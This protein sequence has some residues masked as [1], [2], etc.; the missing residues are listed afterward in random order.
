MGWKK[1][2]KGAK[3]A[4]KSVSDGGKKL[5][6]DS[7]KTVDDAAKDVAD[8]AGQVS[9]Q[10]QKAA[11][12][13]IDETAEQMNAAIGT[14]LD[15]LKSS[16]NGF[17]QEAAKLAADAQKELNRIG[18]LAKALVDQIFLAALEALVDQ[19][20]DD[21]ED[22]IDETVEILEELSKTPDAAVKLADQLARLT[23]RADLTDEV[24]LAFVNL[25]RVVPGFI[26]HAVLSDLTGFK[27]VSYGVFGSRAKPGQSLGADGGLAAASGALS[28]AYAFQIPEKDVPMAVYAGYARSKTTSG[29]TDLGGGLEAASW[30]DAPNNLAGKFL[31]A[32]V[33][34]KSLGNASIQFFF[35]TD[36]TKFLGIN[37]AFGTGEATESVL[38]VF[39]GETVTYLF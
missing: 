35:S 6:E 4:A 11:K 28:K 16:A 8:G 12:T 38:E 39:T 27:S 18:D 37:I 33:T 20:F 24:K 9:K 10:V 30:R 3:K 22:F 1:F 5:V 34:V 15:W 25:T 23:K 13:V 19:L 17:S 31:G 21:F 2:V 36:L 29:S 26:P 7:K 32:A 14:S